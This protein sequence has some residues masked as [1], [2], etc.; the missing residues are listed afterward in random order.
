MMME[1]KNEQKQ[2]KTKQK[3]YLPYNYDWNTYSDFPKKKIK[4]EEKRV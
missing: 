1:E 4:K 3:N 2:N